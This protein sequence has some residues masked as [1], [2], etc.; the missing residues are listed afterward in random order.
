MTTLRGITWE[1][2]R[3]H[4]CLRAAAAEWEFR[5]PSTR[6]TWSAR[7]LQ[8]FADQPLDTLAAEYDLLII[9]HPHI[10]QAHEAGLLLALDATG[11][12]AELDVLAAQSVGLSHRSY[13]H[14]GHQ[15]GLAVDAAAQV[16]V[17]R[18]DLLLDAPGDWD[19]VFE[20]VRTGRVLWAAKPVDVMS[21]FLTLAANLGHPVADRPGEFVDEATGLAV[22]EMLRRLAAAVPNWCLDANPIEIAEALSSTDDWCYSPLAFGYTNYSR[23]GY[24][25]HRVRY[26]DMPRGPGGLSGSCLGGAGIAVSASTQYASEAVEHAFWLASP[27][28]QRGVYYAN[29][30][31]PG[32]SS[33]WDDDAVNDDCLD[34][35]RG[36]RAT[37]EGAWL[38]PRYPGWLNAFDEIGILLNG[39]VRGELTDAILLQ[40]AQASYERS[41]EG[42]A[43]TRS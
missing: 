23:A 41:L 12:D 32:Y 18:P 30:G 6:V 31:Q 19:A 34:F 8:A 11:H 10:P 4:D 20:L 7:S 25:P 38:R 2:P 42:R 14:A 5:H 26:I 13:F 33:A 3:G 22:L 29:G 37:L 17:Y 43:A 27:E 39:A 28:V 9:D 35:F 21:S 15:Y 40:Q 24:R 16:A 1:H 36:T